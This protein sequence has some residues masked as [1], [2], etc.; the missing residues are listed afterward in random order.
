MAASVDLKLIAKIADVGE[1]KS[2]I[3]AGITV[4]KFKDQDAR[5]MFGFVLNYYKNRKTMGNIPTRAL[6]EDHYPTVDLPPSDRLTLSSAIDEF[7]HT[8][9]KARVSKLNDY[10]SDWADS[11]LIMLPKAQQM[12]NDMLKDKRSSV[13]IVVAEAVLEAQ[14]R[15]EEAKFRD[16]LKGIPY[17]WKILNT[18]TQ[19]AQNGEYI[20]FYGRPKSLKTFIGLKV[21]VHAYEF[22]DRRI[23]IYT[24]EMSP[25]QM[26]DR[27][28][29]MLIHAPY[30]AFKKG[31]LHQIP[32]EFGGTKEDE[33]YALMGAIKEDE[34]MLAIGDKHKT[35]V[36]TSDRQDKDGGGVSGLRRK[37]EDHRPDL[38]FVDAV[39]LM[40]NDRS[41]V[42]SV[43]W[44]DQAGI[45]QDLKEVAQDF[46]IPL[47]ATL[48]ANRGSENNKGESAAN[49][50]FSDSYAQD[51]DLA[52]EIIK[53][54]I[55]PLHNELALAITASRETNM[56]GFAIHGNP[57]ENF[58]I[59]EKPVLDRHGEIV[60]GHNGQPM[61]EP[62]IF[63]DTADIWKMFKK[64]E[65]KSYSAKNH[66]D[67]LS[68][69]VTN[70]NV[71]EHKA[72]G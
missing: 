14:Q 54:K 68:S 35:I 47:V 53:K 15:Y 67:H 25:Q 70:A 37:I 16:V 2:V 24:R 11:P 31:Y 71:R 7:L 21:S 34:N 33:F 42:R 44:S 57:C 8:D 48:Q 27:V 38:A 23:L 32:N 49:M 22:A 60:I 39:Y 52:I 9:L 45:S 72:R 56:S 6:L 65:D 61:L 66:L 26:M 64:D 50:S 59:L 51:C 12:I 41:G 3:D 30:D 58:D 63:H 43:K 29:C 20:I 17:P 5:L 36:I 62:V 28:I 18:E 1:I 4:D 19:G 13:D 10:V 69:S 46:N 55:D 40:R